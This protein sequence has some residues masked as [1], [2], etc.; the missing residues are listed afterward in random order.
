M[1]SGIMTKIAG[2]LTLA[3]T[4]L[5]AI[6]GYQRKENKRKQEVIDTH[7]KKDDIQDQIKQGEQD[8]EANKD[9]IDT[10]DWKRNI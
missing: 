7:E 4:I 5:L 3:V 2:A 6:V 1:F 10:D 8:I 9:S